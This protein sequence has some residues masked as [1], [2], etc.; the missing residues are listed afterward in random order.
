MGR[1]LIPSG[2][3][4]SKP[5]Q[6]K[7]VA[8]ISLI[9]GRNGLSYQIFWKQPEN[10]IAGPYILVDSYLQ[11]IK[12]PEVLGGRL[13]VLCKDIGLCLSGVSSFQGFLIADWKWEQG[14]ISGNWY[15][16]PPLDLLL[17]YKGGRSLV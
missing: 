4:P 12:L 7:G 15:S 1:G 17:F 5:F 11:G 8:C 10:Q 14:E 16:S 9:Q 13:P 2:Y 6:V 3:L